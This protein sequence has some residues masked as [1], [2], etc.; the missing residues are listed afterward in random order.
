MA[1]KAPSWCNSQPWQIHVTAGAATERFR[2]G[3]TA[4]A[5]THG[6]HG[7]PMDPDFAFPPPYSGIYKERQ[8]ECGWQLYESVGVAYGDRI[9]SA[10]QMR[11]N[12]RLFGAPHAL[13][14]TSE[15]DL[16]S[17][18]VLDCGVYV[19]NLLLAAQSLGIATIAQAA[20]AGCAPFV[21]DFFGL[22]DNRAVLLGVS[23]GYADPDHPANGFRTRRAALA[24]IAHWIE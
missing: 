2:E 9:A 6:V 14:V 4:Y 21:R 16:G 22:P 12:F 5:E 1:Q 7:V 24:D 23:F 10:R 13:V 19:G 8:R 17:Y 18:G 15:R 11:E 20:V 3:L